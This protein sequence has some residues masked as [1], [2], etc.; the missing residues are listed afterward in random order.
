MTDQAGRRRLGR[1][2]FFG[3]AACGSC[4]IM[5]LGRA[6]GAERAPLSQRPSAPD[7]SLVV[8]SGTPRERGRSYGRRFAAEIGEFLEKDILGTF[9]N[10]KASREQMLRYAEAC[11]PA[12]R[13]L[14]PTITDEMEGMAEGSGLRLEEIVLITLHEELWHRGELPSGEHCTATAVGPPVTADGNTY[15]GLSWDWF[16]QLYGKSQ[17]LVWDRQEGPSVLSYSYPGLWIGAGVNSA[18][19]AL[20]WTSIGDIK[21]PRLS[22]G[23]PSYVLIAHLLYQPTLEAVEEEA[24][25]AGQAGWFT[26]V[27][28]DSNGQMLNLES[29]PEKVAVERDRGSLIRVYYGT[30]EMTGTAP[31]KP[32]PRHPQC[33]RMMDLVD[34]SQ[35]RITLETVQGFY[36][37]HD[38]TI[39][40]HFGTLDAMVFNATRR[41][42]Y[43]TRG[44]G[45]LARWQRFAFAEES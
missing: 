42:A 12:I 19:I 36:G 14:S 35:G 8:V 31:G 41:E 2:E 3:A 4:A 9:S 26:F 30:R 40:K 27:L 29:S 13:R 44:P 43:V 11:L 16:V 20:A 37:D 17:M 24:R 34:A 33:R 5:G 21:T 45:C 18:G 23:V 15:V 10:P 28:A 6:R 39:C 22:A 1:R 25:R 7:H 32:I 38:S